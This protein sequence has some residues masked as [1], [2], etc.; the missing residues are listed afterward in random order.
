MTEA[1]SLKRGDSVLVSHGGSGLGPG[2]WHRAEFYCT[3]G[4][5]SHGLGQYVALLDGVDPPC[6][7]IWRFLRTGRSNQEIAES[8]HRVLKEDG[9]LKRDAMGAIYSALAEVEQR[10]SSQ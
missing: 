10:C 5:S 4:E 2:V 6:Y 9:G 3:L 8:L 7:S 1:R